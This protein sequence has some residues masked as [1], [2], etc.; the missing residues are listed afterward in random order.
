M[1]N[2]VAPSRIMAELRVCF[3][4]IPWRRP[5][6]GTAG[7]TGGVK[8]APDRRGGGAALVAAMTRNEVLDQI[9]ARLAAR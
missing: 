5:A 4:G 9:E 6:F 1:G 8:E 2:R 3:R 7:R